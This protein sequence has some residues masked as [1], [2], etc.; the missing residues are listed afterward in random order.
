MI[1]PQTNAF[2]VVL[3]R[4]LAGKV[5]SS[6]AYRACVVR[7]TVAHLLIHCNVAGIAWMDLPRDEA[8]STLEQA[9]KLWL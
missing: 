3:I 7:S 2:S 8:Q 1:V 9:K 4:R 6:F 5:E